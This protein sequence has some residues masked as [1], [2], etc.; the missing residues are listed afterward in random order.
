MTKPHLSPSSLDLFAKC[1]EAYRRRYID[2]DKIPPGVAAISGQA[3]HRGAQHNF[4]QKIESG[5]DLPASEI[6]DASVAAMDD[7]VSRD[8]VELSAEEADRGLKIVLGEARDIV[9][10]RAAWH[11][12]HQAP[13]WQ[14]HMVEEPLRIVVPDREYDLFGYVDLV[15]EAVSQSRVRQSGL[16]VVDFKNRSKKATQDEAS[17]SVA[18]TF[19]AAAATLHYKEQ[20]SSVVLDV[21][22]A[23]KSGDFDRQVIVSER[24]QKDFAALAAR[25]DM[26]S[27]AIQAGVFPPAKPDAWWC[28]S[29]WCGYYATC[30]YVGGK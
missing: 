19:Y 5:E 30:P 21:S 4:R 14:P 26:V 9:A 1:G 20:V 29:R 7:A 15:A 11:A 13:A 6:V 18:L 17:S 22:V 3:S 16:H 27:R 23:R 12:E 24:G 2:G 28:S 10:K 25:L 8:G